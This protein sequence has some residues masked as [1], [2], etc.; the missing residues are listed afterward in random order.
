MSED[1]SKV[2]VTGGKGRKQKRLK[3]EDLPEDMRQ[4][5]V[6]IGNQ[7]H[8]R[9]QISPLVLERIDAGVN[10]LKIMGLA[11]AKFPENNGQTNKEINAVNANKESTD[12]AS[13]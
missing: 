2:Q 7:L 11:V 5:Y 8:H 13:N 9:G 6:L 10:T 4:H 1:Y 3:L 12:N